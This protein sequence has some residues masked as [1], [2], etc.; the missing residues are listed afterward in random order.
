M[1]E[2][3]GSH[4]EGGG[5]ILRTTVAL[6][7]VTGEDVKVVNIRA[8]RPRPGLSPQHLTSIEAV[9]ALSD[10]SVEGLAPGAREIAFR[11][12]SVLGGSFRFDI[13]TAGSISLVLQSC[14][15]VASA[16][17]RRTELCVTGGTDVNWSPPIDYL[18]SVHLAIAERFDIK[19]SLDLV[20]RGF[21]PEGGGEVRMDIAPCGAL[22]PVKLDSK[23]G[24]R[25]IG[26]VAYSQ[27]LPDHVVS[28]MKHAA[29]KR[30][31]SF[32]RVKVDSDVR[33][34]GSTGAG[35]V[36]YAEC[37]NALLGESSLGRKGLRSE[38]LGEGCASD[39]ME[40]VDSGAT[41]DSHMLDQILPY[42]A[43]AKGSSVVLAEELTPHAKTNMWVIETLLGREFSTTEKEGLVEV[44]VD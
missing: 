38:E 24:V 39:L 20:S 22:R 31:L 11:P 12:E 4:G 16:S 1:I 33:T 41:V 40:T 19:A 18:T 23:G 30:L 44:A 21:Y 28:R 9:A 15:L 25:R 17:K 27:N 10:A 7:A 35:I 14:I 5:Q 2:V 36:L 3:D 13:G 26:G 34:G 42:M 43:L 29:F 32:E 6:S 37:E 8:G